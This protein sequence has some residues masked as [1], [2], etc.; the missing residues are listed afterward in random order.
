MQVHI[1]PIK[2]RKLAGGENGVT[3][4]WWTLPSLH[5]W[6][7][8]G[9]GWSAGST[10]NWA[11]Q[12]I[13]PVVAVE[14]SVA[15]SHLR[16]AER[17]AAVSWE[18][19]AAWGAREVRRATGERRVPLNA[20]MQVFIWAVAA[21]CL[22]V[23]QQLCVQTAAAFGSQLPV[24]RLTHEGADR[25]IRVEHTAE[26]ASRARAVSL[27]RLSGNVQVGGSDSEA[28]GKNSALLRA[29]GGGNV[30]VPVT[31]RFDW[32]SVSRVY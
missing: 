5:E 6:D 24:G 3:I 2:L 30:M 27:A 22:P 8:N 15:V 21:V 20:V 11:V 16:N 4:S 13:A 10:E 31:R 19:C 1:N 14:L 9:F 7:A 32:Q 25:L 29:I 26:L 18:R 12:L 28:F 17:A 23:A